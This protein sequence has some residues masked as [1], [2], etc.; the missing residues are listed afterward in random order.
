LFSC[1]EGEHLVLGKNDGRHDV[2][3]ENKYSGK[4]KISVQS[5]MR[6]MKKMKDRIIKKGGGKRNSEEPWAK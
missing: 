4:I 3:Q 5:I 1:G 2:E 6:A